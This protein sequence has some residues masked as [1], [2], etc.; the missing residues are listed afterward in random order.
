MEINGKVALVTGAAKRVGKEIALE[1]AKSGAHV[2]ITYRTSETEAAKTVSQIKRLGVKSAA[3]YADVSSSED[4]ENAVQ[5]I[6][7]QFRR[8]DILVNNAANFLKVPFTDL[9]E[10]DF[11]DSINTNLKG[12]YL[13]SIAVGKIMLK[14]KCGKIINIADW[15]GE[16]PYKNY[17]PY[18]ISKGGVI[19]LTKA[20]AKSLAPYVQ[21]NA[22]SP[23]AIL[24]PEGFGS[25]EKRK[26]IEGTPLKKIGSPKD[27][28]R[29]IKFLIEGSDFITGAILPVDGGRLIA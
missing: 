5:K 3:Y 4:I 10:K 6:Y 7:R 20:L 13:F 28:A 24:F 14:Q 2:V 18:C 15:A 23:G 25:K 29:A 1:L 17:L 16:R 9:T 26:V 19:T 21:V 27:I 12:P 8:V 11:D 22:V